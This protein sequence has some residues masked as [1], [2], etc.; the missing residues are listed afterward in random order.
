MPESVLYEMAGGVAIITLNRPDS[1]NALNLPACRGLAEAVDRASSDTSAE[2]VLILGQ[3]ANFCVGGDVVS[4]VGAIDRAALLAELTSAVH[5]AVR[6]MHELNKPV[7]AGV[8]GAAAGAGLALA[9]SADLVLVEESAT[10][11]AAFTAVGLTPDT[12]A[13]WLL[14]RAVGTQRALNLMLTNRRLSA[15]EA[16]DW[17]IAV[18]TCPDGSITHRARALAEQMTGEAAQAFGKTR[19][20]TRDALSRTLHDHLDAEAREIVSASA[21]PGAGRLLSKFVA[22]TGRR[23]STV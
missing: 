8:Q 6:R 19:R 20:L 22:R 15:A 16:V 3:G 18:A 14:P 1:S 7:V 5:G 23:S 10:F 9:L 21:S 17:G 2:T 11:L 4:M 12:G 13:S